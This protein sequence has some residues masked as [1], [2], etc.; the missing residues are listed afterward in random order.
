[1]EKNKRRV[2]FL[3]EQRAAAYLRDCGYTILAMNYRCR[4]GE[5][6]IIAC[7]GEYLCFVEVKYRSKSR[8]GRPQE[9]VTIKKQHTICRVADYYR[10][11]QGISPAR[12]MRFDVVAI[13]GDEI[14][15]LRNAFSYCG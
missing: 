9:A 12:S 8:T 3:Q 10:M 6:D 5:I 2:G 1:M 11:R 14:S 7:E 15:L 4:V 13:L